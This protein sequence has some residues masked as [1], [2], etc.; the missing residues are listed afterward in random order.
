MI[1]VWIALGIFLYLMVGGT[2]SRVI[3]L[4]DV[5]SCP[6]KGHFTACTTE[7]S[8]GECKAKGNNDGWY[9]AIVFFWPLGIFAVPYFLC[10]WIGDRIDAFSTRK[11]RQQENYTRS[12]EMLQEAGVHIPTEVLQQMKQGDDR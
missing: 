11:E 8:C 1:W 6:N 9:A 7:K 2:F 4:E 12:I 10:C 5:R 3:H